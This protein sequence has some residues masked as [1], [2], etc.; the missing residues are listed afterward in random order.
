M[1][2]KLL[3]EA[4]PY[5]I[6][7]A[8]LLASSGKAFHIDDAVFLGYAREARLHPL[9]PYLAAGPSNPPGNVWLLAALTALFGESERAL[10][11]A[12]LPFALLAL[13]GARWLAALFG[14]K[15]AWAVPLL[16][17][18]SG[19][20]LLSATTLMPDVTLLAFL[21][22]GVALLWSDEEKPRAWKLAAA[23]ALFATGWTLRISGA[24]VLGLAALVQL[25]RRNW[26]AL[27]PL[28]AL[29]L[30]F[31]GWTVLSRVQTGTAQTLGTARL[32]GSFNTLL[33]FRLLSTAGAYLLTTTLAAA[34][35][36][37][38]PRESPRRIIE[39]CGF[40]LV[41]LAPFTPIGS[42]LLAAG[43]LLFF[44]ARLR[45]LELGGDEVFLW[46]WIAAALAVP[47]LYNQATAKFLNL[48]LAPAAILL[49]RA[50][51]HAAERR[52]LAACAFGLA[53]ALPLAIAD[54]RHAE[55]LRELTLREVAAA[56]REGAAH[57]FVAGTGWGAYEYGPRSGAPYLD[58]SLAPGSPSAA[59]LQPGDQ[60]LDL[61]FP[62]S[63]SLP[64]GSVQLIAQG[65]CPDDFPLRTMADGAGLWSSQWGLL[66]F[67]WSREPLQPWWRVRILRSIR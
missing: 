19:C 53:V 40:A 62:G 5:A 36:L 56:K 57:V 22:P 64:P 25:S 24:P 33:A 3:L 29:V 66:P 67:V 12:L 6:V 14:V 61:S 52:I 63:L 55:A 34:A 9:Q 21:L 49:L 7:L 41:L 35:L 47:T 65:D 13:A 50:C 39:C 48:L 16:L 26:R 58:G 15:Q 38:R 1:R 18:C 54:Q 23:C 17:A 46:L 59:R 43:A 51:E 37:L 45:K 28:S 8:V 60:L 10:H 32:H 31:V 4:T 30:A 20:F 44:A 42:S 2:R 27:W 11:L